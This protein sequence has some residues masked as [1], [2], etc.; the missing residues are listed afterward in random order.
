M[1]YQGQWKDDKY[2]GFGVLYKNGKIYKGEF[3]NGALDGEGIE[4][5]Q[6]SKFYGYF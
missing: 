4:E 2:H 1:I 3:V 5:S 6:G